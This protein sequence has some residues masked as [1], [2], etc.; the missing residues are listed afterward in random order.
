M[1]NVL[2]LLILTLTFFTVAQTADSKKRHHPSP[3]QERKKKRPAFTFTQRDLDNA[4]E[5][6]ALTR[7]LERNIGKAPREKTTLEIVA[8]QEDVYDAA[9]KEYTASILTQ[10][11]TNTS[12]ASS[13]VPSGTETQVPSAMPVKMDVS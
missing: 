10:K 2:H 4:W 1:K 9:I 3:I 13:A 6:A 7:N 5:M 12:A 11:S 8:A